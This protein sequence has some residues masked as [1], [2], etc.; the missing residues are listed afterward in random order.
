MKINGNTIKDDTT[1]LDSQEDIPK[2]TW[3]SSGKQKN[4]IS[5]YYVDDNP[6]HKLNIQAAFLNN[7]AFFPTTFYP[8]NFDPCQ[9]KHLFKSI[10]GSNETYY[11]YGPNE[12][13][14]INCTYSKNA[15]DQID[16]LVLST[17]SFE[18]GTNILKGK[19]YTNLKF[20]FHP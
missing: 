16:I 20:H 15:Q 18:N 2:Y 9:P 17:S 3:F 12:K 7:I 5:G 19:F 6:F 1:Y 14:I 10:E 13:T 4:T 8:L 11:R